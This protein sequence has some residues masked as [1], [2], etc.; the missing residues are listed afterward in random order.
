M[1]E[2][3]IAY[4]NWLEEN[5]KPLVQQDEQKLRDYSNTLTDILFRLRNVYPEAYLFDCKEGENPI[6]LGYTN[7]GQY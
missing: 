6:T 2:F 3:E 5:A 7:L 4:R 1:F